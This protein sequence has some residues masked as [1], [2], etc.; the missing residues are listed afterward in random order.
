MTQHAVDWKGLLAGLMKPRRTQLAAVRRAVKGAADGR[1]AW[2]ALVHQHLV[3]PD[4]FQR[5]MY[6]V[7]CGTCPVDENGDLAYS[8]CPSCSPAGFVFSYPRSVAGSVTLASDPDGVVRAEALAQEAARRVRLWNVSVGDG[9]RWQIESLL[10]AR[11]SGFMRPPLTILQANPR[12]WMQRAMQ[13]GQVIG[14]DASKLE[15]DAFVC[16]QGERIYKA[17]THD[18][19][20]PYAA[21]PNPYTPLVEILEIGYALRRLDDEGTALVAALV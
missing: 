13:E 14:D 4:A 1:L 17:L 12:A 10:R 21:R 11:D 7:P 5:Q 9:T 8:Q 3:P 6:C 20:E 16:W 19:V 2:D 15:T 18:G